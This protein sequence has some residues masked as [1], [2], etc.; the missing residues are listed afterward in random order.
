MGERRVTMKLKSPNHLFQTWLTEW[1][2]EARGT[3]SSLASSYDE[4]LHSLEMYPL[5]LKSGKD[6]KILI[7]F[8]AEICSKIDRMLEKN[9]SKDKH[10]DIKKTDEL[11]YHLQNLGQADTNQ[12]KSAVEDVLQNKKR[13]KTITSSKSEE[14][15]QSTQKT[16]PKSASR[17][18]AKHASCSKLPSV[19]EE[20]FVLSPGGFDIILYVDT[21]EVEGKNTLDPLL[22]ELNNFCV[23]Y[24]VKSLKI[25][26]YIWICRDKVSKKELV[27]PYIIERKRLDD[28]SSSIKD[29]RYYE[30]KFRLKKSG[31]K[32]IY[33][34]IEDYN[35]KNHIGLP[36]PT[37]RQAAINTAIQDGFF[38]K[39]TKNWKHTAKFLTQF[40]TVISN[41]FKVLEF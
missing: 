37:L 28:F 2:N 1:R 16:K 18:I 5:P 25:G 39:E 23:S 24:E 41:T 4:A 33:Y 9:Q 40:T 7:G 30:Q 36:L 38:I 8:T 10:L 27:L 3:N 20:D 12:E 34:L 31:I 35:K 22:Q 26:D 11:L 14:I 32:N 17:K 21:N 15:I 6:C 29:G 13:R 19:Q